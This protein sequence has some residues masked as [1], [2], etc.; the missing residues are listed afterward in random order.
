MIS[1]VRRSLAGLAAL[2][3]LGVG[4]L[5]GCTSAT[6]SSDTPSTSTA[7]SVAAAQT[8]QEVLAADKESHTADDTEYDASS[9]TTVTLDGKTAA[10]SGDGSAQVTVDGSTVTI[11]AEGTY[12]L[13]GSL[14]DGQVIIDAPDA[15]VTLVLDGVDI[16][17][18]TG[19]AIAAT[20]ADEVTVITA[21]GSENTLSDTDSYADDADVNAALYS[22]ADLTLAGTGSL[23]VKGNG[24]DGIAT[25]DGLV[26]ASGAITVEAKDDGIR[27]KDYVVVTDGTLRVTSGGDAI[28]AD[29]D[30]DETA[31]YV[32]IRGGTLTLTTS[33]GDGIDAA[34]DLV[35]TGGT[36]T[37]VT[38]GG[39]SETP[40]DDTSTKGLKSGVLS[41]LEGGEITVEA[42]DDALHSNGSSTLSG[43]KVSVASGDDAVHAED[44][45]LISSG[46]VE[47]TSS[48]E[49]LEAAHITVSGGDTQVISSDDGV[50]AAGGTTDTRAGQA[51]QTGQ[52]G[53][54]GGPGGGGEQVG[55]YSLTITGGT[56]VVDAEGD[57]LDSNGTAS[58]TGGT[59][60]VN[61]P[62]NSGNG[63]LDVNGELT[64]EGGT[65][66]AAGSAGMV[67]SPSTDSQQGWVSATLDTVVEAGTVVQIV[68][69][70]NQVIATYTASK[71]V[72]NVVVSTDGITSGDEYFVYTGGTASG[73]SVGGLAES[74]EIGSATSIATVTADE[75]PAGGM[76]RGGGPR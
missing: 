41:A 9:A 68:N 34:T 55:D 44:E 5:A 36:L 73:D 46:T 63:A 39:H 51:D 71:T 74:G 60:V 25:T 65:L 1:T 23:T 37:A 75:A 31:G 13:S 66:L 3:V 76:D 32:D 49:G 20:D 12:V 67:V 64:V 29:N 26:I 18:S 45:L 59:V 35:V 4:A 15:H 8:A 10:V 69:G 22:A 11:T 72:Q 40:S 14:S 24:N 48:V 6:T 21:D 30:E 2:S 53:F 7:V 61:G 58:M 50:N 17:S 19:A 27:G 42:S 56:L 57:G 38:G 62:S 54:G 70:D 47:V 52:G 33:A 16:A 43:A 28:K